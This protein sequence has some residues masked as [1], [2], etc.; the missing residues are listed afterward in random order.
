MYIY[1]AYFLILFFFIQYKNNKVIFY[2]AC[3]LL[4]LL[5]A[6]K[7]INVG[8]DSGPYIR[9]FTAFALGHAKEVTKYQTEPIWRWIAQIVVFFK[10]SYVSFQL[11]LFIITF[12]PV[13]YVIQKNSKNY[14]LS[15]F[16]FFS[17][18]YYL[19][20]YCIVRQAMAISFL[21][22][23]YSFIKD[24]KLLPAILFFVIAVLCHNLAFLGILAFVFYWKKFPLRLIYILLAVSFIFGLILNQ[25]MLFFLPQKIRDYF[26]WPGHGFRKTLAP[27]TALIG[28]M[29]LTYI[30]CL[31]RGSKESKES[32]WTQ[33]VFLGLVVLNS[34]QKLVLGIRLSQ[35]FM[36]TQIIFWTN[37]IEEKQD[38]KTLYKIGLII[39]SSTYFFA[40]LIRDSIGI[41]PYEFIPQIQKFLHYVNN[42]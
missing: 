16:F 41:V 7:N 42:L 28:I 32:F 19:N 30:T 38:K 29:N 3:S 14:L 21:L 2:Y 11:I 26:L 37:Y 5:L 34:T 15:V 17:F 13:I 8:A 27:Y 23:C 25:G 20:T 39:Y 22:L 31:L 40:L 10:G 36:I 33:T 1:I 24:H 35:F 12:L 6:V 18:F 9:D 4:L